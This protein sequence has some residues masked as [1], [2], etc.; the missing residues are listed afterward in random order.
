MRL[1]ANV[2]LFFCLLLLA[3]AAHSD[4]TEPLFEMDAAAVSGVLLVCMDVTTG[5][6]QTP[7]VAWTLAKN[8]LLE[9]PVDLIAAATQLTALYTI[10]GAAIPQRRN[11]P[12][13]YIASGENVRMVALL[14]VVN[15][16]IYM[17]EI[18]GERRYVHIGSKS[19]ELLVEAVGGLDVCEIGD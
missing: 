11:I 7:L 3:S 16:A 9:K 2:F 17:Q 19:A 12:V 6:I 15:G 8:G 14:G 5:D 4:E 13:L 1:I 18:A 10:P